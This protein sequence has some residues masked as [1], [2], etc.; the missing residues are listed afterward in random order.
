[1]K[2]LE[3]TEEHRSKLLEMCKELFPNYDFMIRDFV[4]KNPSISLGKKS[5]KLYECH[6]HWYEF[7]IEHLSKKIYTIDNQVMSGYEYFV[8]NFRYKKEHPVDYLYAD[9][10]K[11]VQ[12]SPIMKTLLEIIK[13]KFGVSVNITPQSTIQDDCG[14]DSLDQVEL[15]MELEVRY[16]ISIPDEDV[17]I[18][19]NHLSTLQDVE[20]YLISRNV[21]K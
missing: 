10:K 21:T 16:K 9:Y 3:L 1:M 11:R 13:D 2:P 4:E 15:I 6:I 14:L 5:K 18:K 19:F 7:C 8:N 12:I 20:N 17:N